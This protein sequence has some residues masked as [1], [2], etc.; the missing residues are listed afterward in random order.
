MKMKTGLFTLIELLV[1]IAIISILAAMLMPALRN[2]RSSALRIDCAGRMKQIASTAQLY[3]TDYDGYFPPAYYSPSDH[4]GL[5]VWY[6]YL[7]LYV[8][9]P[10]NQGAESKNRGTIYFCPGNGKYYNGSTAFI[11]N[12]S[13][14]YNA[15]YWGSQPA[16]RAIRTME[17]QKPAMFCLFADGRKYPNWGDKAVYYWISGTHV[18]IW[19]PNNYLMTNP[20]QGGDNLAFGDGHVD[21]YKAGA[22]TDKMMKVEYSGQTYL[23]TP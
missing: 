12:Y 20:H 10:T 21:Y 2:A 14:N 15:G 6:E 7:D 17:I 5:G 1:V 8:P 16:A 4:G 3:S 23:P 22:T 11:T 19:V 9:R 18:R 13:W